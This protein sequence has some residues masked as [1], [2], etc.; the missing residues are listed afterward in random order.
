MS[1]STLS[2][3]VKTTFAGTVHEFSVSLS[4]TDTVQ[5]LKSRV[6]GHLN[7]SEVSHNLRLIVNGRLVGADH[8]TVEAAGLKNDQVI[9]A[10]IS[11][12]PSGTARSGAANNNSGVEMQSV[13]GHG[14]MS[15]A[16]TGPLRGMDVLMTAHTPLLRGLPPLSIDEV[17]AL[18]A[19]FSDSIDS[20]EA[21]QGRQTGE[22]QRQPGESDTDYR[23]RVET[24][25]MQAQ[26]PASEFR[27]NLTAMPFIFRSDMIESGENDFN[28]SMAPQVE[29]AAELGTV[30]D[31]FYGLLMGY[32]LGFIVLF[33]MWDRNI[34]YRQKTG[35]LVGMLLQMMLT[36]TMQSQQPHQQGLQAQQQQGISSLRGGAGGAENG[37]GGNPNAPILVGGN[38]GRL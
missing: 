28:V 2:I 19:Y 24:A 22:L 33:C 32:L 27:L 18:R 10:A 36:V 38:P 11:P 29:S 7:I 14:S 16:A 20:F 8:M 9:H 15:R 17:A 34:P 30:K 37:A 26:G 31:F 5:Q 1:S 4:P 6:A 12:R 35:I 3:R 13:A 25:W 21:E 23:Y